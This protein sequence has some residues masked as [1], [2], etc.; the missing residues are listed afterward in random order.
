MATIHLIHGFIGFGKTTIAKQLAHELEEFSK[1]IKNGG[2]NII[3]TVR[4][5]FNVE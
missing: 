4:K 2:E 3:A 5:W 1:D